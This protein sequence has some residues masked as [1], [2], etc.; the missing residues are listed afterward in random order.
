MTAT[1]RREIVDAIEHLIEG[2]ARD[3][4]DHDF[5]EALEEM[6]DRA[7]TALVARREEIGGR[8]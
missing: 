6:E 5:I 7:Q 1:R 2:W 3:L 8:D 4:G